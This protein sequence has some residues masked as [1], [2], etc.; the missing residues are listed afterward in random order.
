MENKINK[1]IKQTIEN[2]KTKLLNFNSRNP[3]IKL[4]NK[5]DSN[6]IINLV[7]FNALDCLNDLLS[8]KEIVIQP[9]PELTMSLYEKYKNTHIFKKILDGKGID[10]FFD[11]KTF[12]SDFNKKITKEPYFSYWCELNKINANSDLLDKEN[13]KIFT[14]RF[15]EAKFNSKIKKIEKENKFY[16]E[17]KGIHS[18]FLNIGNI[19]YTENDH[20]SNLISAPLILIP[21]N[22]T[23]KNI[24]SEQMIAIKYNNQE[25]IFNEI[26]KKLLKNDYNFILESF[27][28][29]D[30]SEIKPA[31]Q[32][33]NYILKQNKTIKRFNSLWDLS[34]CVDINI[35]FTQNMIL[36]NDLDFENW[37]NFS[38]IMEN[39]I[40]RK[41]IDPNFKFIP[42]NNEPPKLEDLRK[43]EIDYPVIFEADSSQHSCIVSA[44]Q[45]NSFVIEGP[46]GT[47]K[48]QTISN[49]IISLVSQ[50]KKVLFLSEKSAALEVVKNKLSSKGLGELCLDLHGDNSDKNLVIKSLKE[51]YE[52]KINKINL[53]NKFYPEHTISRNILDS[54][55][56]LDN[57]AKYIG[58]SNI[59]NKTNNELIFS[60][61]SDLEKNEDVFKDF[62][63]NSENLKYDQ[64]YDLIDLLKKSKTYYSTVMKNGHKNNIS[65]FMLNKINF[66]K[67]FN[68]NDN[69]YQLLIQKNIEIIELLKYPFEF[70]NSKFEEKLTFSQIR[71]MTYNFLYFA[72]I[73]N[74]S[75]NKF[76]DIE[77][78]SIN[79]EKFKIQKENIEKL[80]HI[81]LE[82]INLDVSDYKN[83]ISVIENNLN[84]LKKYNVKEIIIIFNTMINI[85][86][87]NKIYV[88][89][90]G[91]KF[92]YDIEGVYNL[93]NFIKSINYDKDKI[94]IIEN[95]KFIKK[96]HNIY[97]IHKELKK[98]IS[99]IK[100]LHNNIK[101]NID[102]SIKVD[103]SELVD[104]IDIY[105]NA[106]ALKKIFSSEY[107]D[108][109]KLLKKI[110]KDQEIDIYKLKGYS[111]Y[112]DLN[113]KLREKK[114]QT[115]GNLIKAE[116]TEIEELDY[117]LNWYTNVK[118]I[119]IS[120]NIY[121]NINDF[122]IL[123]IENINILLDINLEDLNKYLNLAR[124]NFNI[125]EDINIHLIIQNIEHFKERYLLNDEISLEEILS[126]NDIIL[127]VLKYDGKF[128]VVS[129]ED[130]KYVEK[131]SDLISDKKFTDNY[132]IYLK[133]HNENSDIFIKQSR[134]YLENYSKLMKS[135]ENN[136]KNIINQEILLITLKNGNIKNIEDIKDSLEKEKSI[137]SDF[138]NYL[139][140]KQEINNFLPNFENTLNYILKNIDR[141][142]VK[143][144]INNL[145]GYV[146]IQ[147]QFKNSKV[148]NDFNESEYLS[149][150]NLFKENLE[151]ISKL[152]LSKIYSLLDNQELPRGIGGSLI[153]NKTEEEFLKHRM[154]SN[155]R[156]FSSIRSLMEKA[157]ETVS[158][159]KPIFMMSPMSVP[160]F[161]GKGDMNFDV[162]IID[163]ASQMLPEYAISSIARCSQVI[164]TGDSNQLP[165]MRHFF[166]NIEDEQED[167]EIE[168][169]ES[170]LDLAENILDFKCY[171]QWHYRS[172]HPSLIQFSNKHFYENKLKTF[173]SAKENDSLGIQFYYVENATTNDKNI[174]D[175]E[176]K[177]LVDAFIVDIKRNPNKT[178]GIVSINQK[179]SERISELVEEAKYTDIE[180][181]NA[182]KNNEILNEKNSETLF[183]K[184]L[185][186]VQG[187]E[188][189]VIYISIV[190]AKKEGE[191][192][193]KQQFG[194]INRAYGWRF[195]NVLFSRAKYKMNVF[196]SILPHEI[197]VNNAKNIK[198]LS[199]LKD[200]LNYAKN[201]KETKIICSG[202]EPDSEFEI[203]VINELNKRGF[204]CVPQVGMAGF[205]IDIGVIDPNNDESFIL[206][207]ECDGA[208]YHSSKIAKDRDLLRQ[209]ILES[210]G[211]EIHRIWSTNWF[212]NRNDEIEKLINRLNKIKK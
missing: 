12:F 97:E 25:I 74:G 197:K 141:E 206:G 95:K 33:I 207:V 6:K 121:E 15:F 154:K 130:N 50:G 48:S 58:C 188:R 19:N 142:N 165:P 129:E 178:Y 90:L 143:N 122:L 193:L 198:S 81:N 190:F 105:L 177:K 55:E 161:L 184:N 75:I 192:I 56:F 68:D 131:I 63:M 103:Y 112:L 70:L 31:E 73:I 127:S 183:I 30:D 136:S 53:K 173:P 167:V 39:N 93:I 85:D 5:N 66:G 13:G 23:R 168:N 155:V 182:L 185:E 67:E 82:N 111:Y 119:F 27:N 91:K 205:F 64:R 43:L 117:L 7:G 96:E 101:D 87:I 186:N 40:V 83:T 196:C 35:N 147:E 76:P 174:N 208:T 137:K 110:M 181:R 80:K 11:E 41:I 201:G 99:K 20:S 9:I 134:L 164:I 62:Y 170:I 21:V 57:Y 49:I 26:I 175:I 72:K 202:R 59:F 172:K 44:I 139:K 189:D 86:K 106:G 69:D 29:D 180:F 1:D 8:E 77:S 163:E 210:Y 156:S 209:Q 52:N 51:R 10:S 187:D 24:K 38:N 109:F 36:Y 166:S 4:P 200:F 146:Y 138:I 135:I 194:S 150:V 54:K 152:T 149:R 195:L 104:S 151:I 128:D 116:E 160:Q 162:L 34:L 98:I 16:L 65:D 102:F 157:F 60:V 2:I 159:L 46:P 145:Y 123:D 204:K 28:I 79:I 148:L 153:K 100:K 18:L 171:L 88:N 78:I 140:V 120:E 47:G 84:F 169:Y 92:N 115:F 45:G 132:E 176:A 125:A 94:Y 118:K 199:A 179:Q 22:I 108:S 211:W 124:V 191:E 37:K 17:E 14:S 71:E 126:Y 107:K 133:I 42:K 61:I 144:F 158:T 203:Q 32:I 3:L 113:K 89:I 212:R 114:Y